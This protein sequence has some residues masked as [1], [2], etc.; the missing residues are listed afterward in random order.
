VEKWKCGE[1]E[2]GVDLSVSFAASAPA[3]RR[4]GYIE[5]KCRKGKVQKGKCGAVEI[6]L[7]MDFT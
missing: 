5:W 1:E 4:Q 7:H 2:T 3:C 6:N